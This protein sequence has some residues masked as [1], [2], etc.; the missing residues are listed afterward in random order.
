MNDAAHIVNEVEERGARLSIGRS[1]HDPSDPVGKLFNVLSMVAGFEAD[2]IRQR[3]CECMAVAKA[4]GCLKDKK[5]KLSPA[6]ERHLVELMKAGEHTTSKVAALMGVSR[7]TAYRAMQ[8]AT[9]YSAQADGETEAVSH[10]PS[11]APD[12]L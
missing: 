10:S 5:P 9:L 7:A 2:L 3:T 11:N 6:Q 1:V 4:R 12:C 8:R